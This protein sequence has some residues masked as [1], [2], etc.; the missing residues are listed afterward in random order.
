MEI[1]GESC[2]EQKGSGTVP[3]HGQGLV[4]N[5]SIR[6]MMSASN[7]LARTEL[8]YVTARSFYRDSNHVRSYRTS[9]ISISSIET[10]TRSSPCEHSPKS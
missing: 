1:P 3:E 7:P 6:A 10:S 4:L 5:A 2:R 8:P 9:T